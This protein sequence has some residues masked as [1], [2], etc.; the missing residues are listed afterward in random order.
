MKVITL[1]IL[2]ILLMMPFTAMAGTGS[3]RVIHIN[4]D[5]S[6]TDVTDENHEKGDSKDEDGGSSQKNTQ[7]T[8]K[9][10]PTEDRNNSIKALQTAMEKSYMG[11]TNTMID[12]LFEGS[13]SI[14][15]TDIETDTNGVVS[16]TAT[17]KELN[18]FKHPIVVPALLISG[19]FLLLS[20]IIVILGSMLLAGFQEH[21]PEVYGDWKRSASGAY[22]PYNPNRVHTTCMWAITRP[23]KAIVAFVLI[24]LLRNYLITSMLQTSSGVLSSATDNIFIRAIT[25]IAMFLSAFQTQVGEYGVYAFGALIFVMYI[26]TDFVVLFNAPDTAKNIELV[27]WGAFGVFC[28]CDLIRICCTSFG[29]ITSQWLGSQIYVTVGIVFGAILNIV[30]VTVLLVYAVLKGK[31]VAGV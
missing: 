30:F 10:D 21:K 27:A 2:F 18:P 28:L 29:V 11:Y 1:L 4:D 20:T 14:Y 16:Y 13:V 25:G 3:V 24:I 9:V 8:I 12:D 6:K 7:D 17:A 31:K 5:G 15:A 22:A 23:A 19:V 26:I